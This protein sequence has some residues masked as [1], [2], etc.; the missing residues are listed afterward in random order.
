MNINKR[1]VKRARRL[2]H[3]LLKDK[4]CHPLYRDFDKGIDVGI[5]IAVARMMVLLDGKRRD[6]G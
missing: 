5:R 6:K 4:Y 2:C 1:K 3:K